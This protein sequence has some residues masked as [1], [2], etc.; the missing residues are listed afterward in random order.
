MI[1][2]SVIVDGLIAGSAFVVATLEDCGTKTS[3]A[4]VTAGAVTVFCP[5]AVHALTD[6]LTI[7]AI[8]SLWSFFIM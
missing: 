2:S 8:I 4:G 1:F 3:G 6:A 5:V 7:V